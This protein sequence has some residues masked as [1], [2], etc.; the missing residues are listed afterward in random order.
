MVK[1]SPFF[2]TVPILGLMALSFSFVGCRGPAR[3]Q[4]GR[5]ADNLGPC[6]PGI[7]TGPIPVLKLESPTGVFKHGGVTATENEVLLFGIE[8]DAGGP[9]VDLEEEE[10]TGRG[11]GS[12]SGA[13]Q[14]PAANRRYPAELPVPVPSLDGGWGLLWVEAVPPGGAV[15]EW[16]R[17]FFTRLM[18][19]ELEGGRW[20]PPR[21]V[22]EA[23]FRLRWETTRDIEVSPGG[24]SYLT[25]VAENSLS[26]SDLLF[27]PTSGP[28]ETVPLPSELE[29]IA[30]SSLISVDSV[31]VFFL[32][33]QEDPQA[34]G[35]R[36]FRISK[37]LGEPGWQEAE[38]IW[39]GSSGGVTSLRAIAGPGGSPH[40][41]WSDRHAIL[42]HLW[43]DP[44]S[45]RWQ[46]DRV[47]D[48]EGQP[49]Q[50]FAHPDA[51][52]APTIIRLILAKTGR[53]HLE[54]SRWGLTG[55]SEFQSPFP[56]LSPLYLFEGGSSLGEW[57]VGWSGGGVAAR[58]FSPV[59]SYVWL[60]SPFETRFPTEASEQ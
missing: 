2:S 5:S 25:L 13:I 21:V 52:E 32:A 10:R 51:C 29:P 60:L 43:R 17:F 19:S 26:K 55:W 7:P 27:G 6:V 18:Y 56:E 24:G 4:D 9:G 53:T 28:M 54:I 46:T 42:H 39:D 44:R 22:A 20:L 33:Q 23:D 47:P 12:R 58:G 16:P 41:I 37:P 45:G 50:W 3:D 8:V 59:E 31:E 34:G 14:L 40:L 35:S 57:F 49:L 38:L 48:G 15:G 11:L 1:K 30:G 36:V